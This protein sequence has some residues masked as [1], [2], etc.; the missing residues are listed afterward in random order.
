MDK[1]DSKGLRQWL[2]DRSCYAAV[3]VGDTGTINAD[4][5]DDNKR[6][7]EKN[8]AIF[9]QPLTFFIVQDEHRIISL[10]VRNETQA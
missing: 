3:V 7:E 10:G 6:N 1:M 9:Y 4:D 2:G 5:Q 8:Q